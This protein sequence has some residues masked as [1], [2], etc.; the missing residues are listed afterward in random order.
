MGCNLFQI[1][2]YRSKLLLLQRL[3]EDMKLQMIYIFRPCE[4][5]DSQHLID[6]CTCLKRFFFFFFGEKFQRVKVLKSH[7]DWF[8]GFRTKE[9]LGKLQHTRVQR[10]REEKMA[11]KKRT[12]TCDGRTSNN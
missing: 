8:D 2:P 7:L 12:S 4:P 9:H 5:D 3:R 11:G 1:E 6:C 10:A